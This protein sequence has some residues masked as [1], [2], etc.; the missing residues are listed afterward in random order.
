MKARLIF[1]VFLAALGARIRADESLPDYVPA[2]AV[3]GI[4]RSRG[5]DQM[6]ALLKTWQRGF[7]RFH[8]EARFEDTLK[9]S[10]SGLYGL[11]MR[12]ADFAFMGRPIHPFE[13]Y[14]TYERG[15]VFPVEIE[16]ATGSHS[17]PR[18]SPAVAIMVHPKNPLARLTVRQLDGIFGARR[19]GGWV[20]LSWNAAAA[21]GPEADLRTWGQ[22]G[23]TGSLASQPIHVYGAPNLGAGA[24]SYFEGRVFGGAR[25]WNEALREVRD[26][27]QLVA[28]VENDPCAIGYAA[29][30]YA[31]PGVK[32]LALAETEA[33]PFCEPTRETV[34]SRRYPLSRSVYVYYTIDTPQ[35]EISATRGDPRV[36]EFV[37]YI[38][39][40]QGQADVANEGSYLPLTAAVGAAQRRKMDATDTPLER[41]VLLP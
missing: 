29:L 27:V 28:A 4:L 13:R 33:G 24:V 10:A 23:V 5:N 11:E 8:P 16:V 34:S 31:T 15:W 40:A 17:T 21:R 25:I 35:A 32:V 37:R 41:A 3:T 14:G 22:L 26:P 12:T 9:G 38:L 18:K 30:G 1:L 6:A 36:R 39:S 7:Q 20:G 2:M 19:T